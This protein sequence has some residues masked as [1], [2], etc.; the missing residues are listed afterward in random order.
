MTSAGRA[1]RHH[2]RRAGGLSVAGG[3]DTPAAAPVSMNSRL[4]IV[5]IGQSNPN[6]TT[7]LAAAY[8][9][10]TVAFNPSTRVRGLDQLGVGSGR[11]SP[12]SRL[13]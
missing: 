6:S 9:A 12:Q 3:R 1:A 7:G 10:P 4:F 5:V 11:L 13:Y 8:A 2:G